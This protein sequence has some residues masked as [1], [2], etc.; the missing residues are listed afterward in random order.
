MHPAL[1]SSVPDPLQY[2]LE[3]VGDD[4]MGKGL[5]LKLSIRIKILDPNTWGRAWI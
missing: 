1:G 4:R 3:R 2:P 5:V